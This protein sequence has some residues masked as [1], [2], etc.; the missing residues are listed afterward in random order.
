MFSATPAVASRG[1]V[2]DKIRLMI[3][4]LLAIFTYSG[5]SESWRRLAVRL[6][7]STADDVHPLLWDCQDTSTSG[8]DRSTSPLSC[9]GPT[10]LGNFSTTIGVR[11]RGK[12]RSRA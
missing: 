1:E 8:R 4:A 5:M 2:M 7:S 12:A 10:C 11:G 9:D 6:R 3:F